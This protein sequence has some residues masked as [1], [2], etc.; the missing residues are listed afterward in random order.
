MSLRQKYLSFKDYFL[1]KMIE[2]KLN[3]TQCISI[4]QMLAIKFFITVKQPI[5]RWDL[6]LLISLDSKF[7]KLNPSPKLYLPLKLMQNVLN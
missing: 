3:V 7:A 2:I 6:I 1:P 5:F 4:W